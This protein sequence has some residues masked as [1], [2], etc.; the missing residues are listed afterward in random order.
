[1]AIE[2]T[3][4]RNPSD[5]SHSGDVVVGRTRNTT[6]RDIA[7]RGHMAVIKK[8]HTRNTTHVGGSPGGSIPA[9]IKTYYYITPGGSSGST[10]GTPPPLPAT[11][12]RIVTS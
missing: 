1:M 7:A 6:S 12:I 8:S 5:R 9:P 11:V 3:T 4:T 2:D 10:T